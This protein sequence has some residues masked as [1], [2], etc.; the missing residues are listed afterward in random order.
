[1]WVKY[2]S[3]TLVNEDGS[4]YDRDAPVYNDVLNFSWMPR[5]VDAQPGL[6][7]PRFVDA[8]PGLPDYIGPPFIY[9]DCRFQ[10]YV[11]THP[12]FVPYFSWT[13]SGAEFSGLPPTVGK[14][15]PLAFKEGAALS[16]AA[17]E[18][19]GKALASGNPRA[20]QR[21][22]AQT[23]GLKVALASDITVSFGGR[24][25]QH[26]GSVIRTTPSINR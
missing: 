2:A 15:S 14:I 13:G 17:T 22:L 11:T 3:D 23:P 26:Y 12:S 20:V 16:A 25:I 19:D 7:M 8:Q 10:F 24:D 4:V 18:V 21:Y 1:M 5:F 9:E 6:P